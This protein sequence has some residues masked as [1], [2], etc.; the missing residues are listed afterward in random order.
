MLFFVR[1]VLLMN[2]ACAVQ[3]ETLLDIKQILLDVITDFF[4]THHVD[5]SNAKSKLAA[6]SYCLPVHNMQRC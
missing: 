4:F 2:A 6:R 1:D 5:P 3:K